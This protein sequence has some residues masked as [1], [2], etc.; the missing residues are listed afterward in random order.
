[1]IECN[2]MR[3]IDRERPLGLPC[4]PALLSRLLRLGLDRQGGQKLTFGVD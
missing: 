4:P 1:M 3:V 2:C